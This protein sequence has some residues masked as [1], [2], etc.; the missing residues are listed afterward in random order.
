MVGPARLLV[1]GVAALSAWASVRRGEG[2]ATAGLDGWTA[3]EGERGGSTAG[4]EAGWGDG[5]A[6]AVGAPPAG[7]G[8]GDATSG[9]GEGTAGE[10]W[11]EA[12]A[13]RAAVALLPLSALAAT[14]VPSRGLGA[15]TS[16][17]TWSSVYSGMGRFIT[18]GSSGVAPGSSGS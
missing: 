5:A 14:S 8:S 16:A 3:G 4:G 7:A 17:L 10:G 9:L 18:T 13:G 15:L 6:A 11:G 2:K 1:A 12:T